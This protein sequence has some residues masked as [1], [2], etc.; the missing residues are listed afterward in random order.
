MEIF[1]IA[2]AYHGGKE[3]A[4][5]TREHLWS[6]IQDQT[7]FLADDSQSIKGA[8]RDAFIQLN[9]RMAESRCESI[10]LS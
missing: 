1:N 5:Y 6:V 9:Y 8:I 10:H 7:K 4:K 2:Q 3:V